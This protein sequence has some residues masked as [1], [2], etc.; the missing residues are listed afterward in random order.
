MAENLGCSHVDKIARNTKRVSSGRWNLNVDTV[1]IRQCQL[2]IGQAVT[3]YHLL[4]SDA[5]ESPNSS[6]FVVNVIYSAAIRF[7]K[8]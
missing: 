7:T 8:L 3:K 1:Y 4:Q 2:H 5:K 6:P